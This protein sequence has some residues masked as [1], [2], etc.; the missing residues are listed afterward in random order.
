MLISQNYFSVVIS[1]MSEV[2]SCRVYLGFR[3]VLLN[4][5]EHGLKIFMCISIAH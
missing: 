3:V 2:S 5:I 1:V 4:E